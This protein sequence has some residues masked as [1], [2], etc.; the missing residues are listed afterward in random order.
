MIRVMTRHDYT[1]AVEVD[2]SPA[3]D[4]RTRHLD[5]PLDARTV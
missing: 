5:P 4:A 3:F 1:W 2:R